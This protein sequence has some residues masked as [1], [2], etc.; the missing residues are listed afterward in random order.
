MLRLL[1]PK[2]WKKKGFLPVFDAQNYKVESCSLLCAKAIK[3]LQAL[4]MQLA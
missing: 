2:Y 1:R 4:Q 3:D